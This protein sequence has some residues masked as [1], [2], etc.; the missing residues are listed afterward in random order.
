MPVLWRVYIGPDST[1]VIEAN[2]RKPAFHKILGGFSRTSILSVLENDET[3]VE[4]VTRLQ[5]TGFSIISAGSI[6]LESEAQ[7]PEF[8][9]EKMAK[10]VERL[11]PHYKYI[12]IDSPP[13]VPYIDSDIIAGAVDGIVIVVEA[14][15][16]RAEVLD[17]AISRL[18]SVDAPIVGLI[19]NKRVFHIPKWLYNFSKI[20]VSYPKYATITRFNVNSQRVC[21]GYPC[22]DVTRNIL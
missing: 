4:A 19:L 6:A 16:T 20:R 11:K 12:L 21:A 1:L 14:N 13:I 10:V 9:L 15:S 2:L 18:K 7:S 5:D 3:A 17:F 22:T 8:Y